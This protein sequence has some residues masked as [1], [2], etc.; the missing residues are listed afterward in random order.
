MAD[1]DLTVDSFDSIPPRQ[2]LYCRPARLYEK[3]YCTATDEV[4]PFE[5]Y[6]LKGQIQI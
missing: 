2:L 6:V 3:F 1:S 4:V 5:R